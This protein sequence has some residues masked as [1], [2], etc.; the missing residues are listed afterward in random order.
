MASRAG[1]DGFSLHE[2]RSLSRCR[3]RRATRTVFNIETETGN[4]LANGLLAHNSHWLK[5]RKTDWFTVT[6]SLANRCDR[7]YL[8]TGTPIPNWGHEIY[9]TLRLL[10]PDDRRFTSY[11]RWLET[12][13]NIIIDPRRNNS[14]QPQGLLPGVTWEQ[15]R[16]ANGINRKMLRRER[17]EVTPWL[18]PLTEQY[19]QVNMTRSQQALYRELRDHYIAWVEENGEEVSAWSAGG[20]H[21]K[22][23]QVQTGVASVSRE[24]LPLH[25]VLAGSGK[26]QMVE[27][28]ITDHADTPLILFCQYRAT[29]RALYRLCVE[30]LHKRTT[31][32]WGGQGSG[33][34]GA[35]VQSWRG[36]HTDV[37]IGTLDTM[38]EGLTLTEATTCI[39]VERSWRPTRNQQALWRLHREGQTRP[40]HII[41]LITRGGLDAR[42]TR[43]LTDKTEETL[44]FMR[45]GEFR[46]IL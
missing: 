46:E 29:A 9:T 27:Q 30:R 32:L 23:A 11:W 10:Y 36:G 31:L 6:E 3:E 16:E 5:G 4:Y 34:R 14:R 12:W 1:L 15:F 40:V 39:F 28:M 8:L 17:E 38:A 2:S 13:F 42:M 41:Y 35:I 21:T 18:P 25:A 44:R 45:A 43:V 20:L 7:L 24:E 19:V 37:L 33:E 22:L 26:L